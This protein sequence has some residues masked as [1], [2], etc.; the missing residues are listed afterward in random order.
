M[1]NKDVAALINELEKLHVKY[2]SQHLALRKAELKEAKELVLDH[3]QKEVKATAKTARKKEISIGDTVQIKN[4]RT[5]QESTGPVIRI[6]SYYY[7]VK[8]AKEDGT[9]T[10]VRRAK[11]NLKRI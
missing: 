2:E 7:T 8:V 3:G 10:E 1:E 4:P 11:S 9:H 5:P 6:G